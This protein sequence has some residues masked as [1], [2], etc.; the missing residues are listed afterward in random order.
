MVIKAIITKIEYQ[1][2]LG[3][4]YDTK[5]LFQCLL[6]RVKSPKPYDH[7]RGNGSNGILPCHFIVQYAARKPD[8]VVI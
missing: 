4:R 2:K 1:E 3:I 7:M 8:T 6:L 5:W